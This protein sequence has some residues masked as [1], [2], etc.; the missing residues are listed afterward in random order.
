MHTT[1]GPIVNRELHFAR[2]PFQAGGVPR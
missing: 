2:R 1:D